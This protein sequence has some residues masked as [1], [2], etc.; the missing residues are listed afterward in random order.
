MSE[1][2]VCCLCVCEVR[3]GVVF[4][5]Y[6]TLGYGKNKA[7]S[8]KASSKGGGEP[9]RDHQWKRYCEARNTMTMVF[10]LFVRVR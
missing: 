6:L 1:R 10:L 3:C 9:K 7:I 4:L 8:N 2:L 5:W